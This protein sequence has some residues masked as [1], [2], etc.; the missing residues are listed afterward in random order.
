LTDENRDKN[1]RLE[2]EKAN[3]ALTAAKVLANVGLWDDAISRCY[4][5][6]FHAATAALFSL[7]LQAR[8]HAG[9][10]DLFFEHFVRTGPLSRRATKDFA[11]LQRFREQADYSTPIRFDTET[12][13]EEIARATQFLDEVSSVL[14]GR[15][16]LG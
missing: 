14:R 16:F 4:Y 3:M 13:A 10:H 2:I 12:A 15:G 8:T 7:G 9:T 1:T 5:A 11:A 6:A